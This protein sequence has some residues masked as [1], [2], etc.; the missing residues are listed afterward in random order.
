MATLRYARLLRVLLLGGTLCGALGHATGRTP[1][2]REAPAAHRAPLHHPAASAAAETVVQIRTTPAP[3]RPLS[4]GAPARA[5]PPR[6]PRFN[7]ASAPFVALR[8]SHGPGAAAGTRAA[9]SSI[10]GPARYDA[11]QGAVIGLAPM[12]KR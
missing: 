10:G 8:P 9:P 2:A 6:Q 5:H 11:R 3:A 7:P 4:P 1:A 12:R